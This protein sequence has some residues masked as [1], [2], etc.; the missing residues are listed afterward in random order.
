MS[1]KLVTVDAHASLESLMP[2]FDQGLVVI[3][4]E[5]EHFS[6]LITRM[7]VLNHLRRKLS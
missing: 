5:H 4:R 2:L 1:T 3:V 7:D 6:G